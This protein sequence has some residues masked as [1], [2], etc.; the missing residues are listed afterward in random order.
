MSTVKLRV[1]YIPKRWEF[2][3]IME[4]KEFSSVN[5]LHQFISK[6][7]YDIVLE[8]IYDVTPKQPACTCSCYWCLTNCAD[9]N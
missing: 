7:M 5:K 6:N 4:Q 3:G 2:I 8:W 1:N 9:N